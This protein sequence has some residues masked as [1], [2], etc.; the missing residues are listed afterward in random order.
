MDSPFWCFWKSRS[1][2][3]S[4]LSSIEGSCGSMVS[5]LEAFFCLKILMMLITA[6]ADKK[7]PAIQLAQELLLQP[8]SI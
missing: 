2:K 8:L 5:R 1:M 3:F 4:Y 6:A 7:D